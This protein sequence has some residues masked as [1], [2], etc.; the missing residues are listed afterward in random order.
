MALYS[1]HYDPNTFLY[2]QTPLSNPDSFASIDGL[3]SKPDAFKALTSLAKEEKFLEAFNWIGKLKQQKQ[4]IK[5]HTLTMF[6]L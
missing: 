2:D 3:L 1:L 6:Y 4:I 5:G